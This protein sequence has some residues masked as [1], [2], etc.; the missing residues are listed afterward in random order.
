MNVIT[1]RGSNDWKFGGRVSWVPKSL[2]STA[3]DVLSRDGQMLNY[4][5]RDTSWS[6]AASAYASGPIIPDR[7]FFYALYQQGRARSWGV[8]RA[9]ASRQ[10]ESVRTDPL[11]LAKLD[12]NITDN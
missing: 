3:P 11:W 9:S 2:R 1:K 7:L 8:T 5:A 10:I 6:A 12:W 4:N